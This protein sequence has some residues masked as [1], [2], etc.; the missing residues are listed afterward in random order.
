M[1]LIDKLG[2]LRELH[3][4]YRLL[5]TPTAAATDMGGTNSDLGCLQD[6]FHWRF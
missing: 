6:Y 2:R 3:S 4:M 1:F 5:Y